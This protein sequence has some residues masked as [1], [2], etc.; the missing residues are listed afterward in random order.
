MDYTSRDRV[1]QEM[2]SVLASGSSVD[3]N[4]IDTL[5]TA[6]SRAWDRK[7]TGV[8]DSEN[9]FASGSVSGEIL[10]GQVSSDGTKI[11]CYPHKPIVDSVS[12]FSFQANITQTAYTVDPTRIEVY[13]PRV[14]A[15]PSSMPLNCPS[16]CR[17]NINYV[18]GLGAS[19]SDLPEDLVEAVTILAIR[20][21]RE[22]ETGLADQ[23]AIAELGQNIYTKAW[24]IRVQETAEFYRRKVGWRNV[25]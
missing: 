15:Y 25:A 22:T 5:I 20:F 19:L 6:A 1:I 7:C 9:Y 2:H 18:G 3:D 13:G 17:V 11:I 8:P 24:P 10:V 4:L 23:V 12:S 21:Y 16:K 14:T